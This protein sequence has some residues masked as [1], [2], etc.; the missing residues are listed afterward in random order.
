MGLAELTWSALDGFSR[1]LGIAPTSKTFA[2]A[3]S[4]GPDNTAWRHLLPLRENEVSGR[5]R[6]RCVVVNHSLRPGA[7]EA[8]VVAERAWRMG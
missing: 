1:R 6:G 8:A 5:E 3:L 7:S 2:V 4:G